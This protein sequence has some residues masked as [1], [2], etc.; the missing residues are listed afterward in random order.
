[1]SGRTSNLARRA[2]EPTLWFL[3]WLACPLAVLLTV[4]AVD[5]FHTPSELRRD[6]RR[7]QTAPMRQAGLWDVGL[8]PNDTSERLLGLEDDVAYRE[9]AGLY[10]KVE[11]GRVDYQG[12]P[13]LESMRAKAQYELTILSRTD[14][15]PVRQSRLLTLY[16]VM[17][18]D[19]RPL[20]DSERR[21]QLQKAAS[22]FRNAI[23]LDPTNNDAKTNLE[24][25]LATFGPVAIVGPDPEGGASQ[26]NTSGQGTTGSG[27]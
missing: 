26:G 11:P 3:G 12:F 19:A 16:G 22:A 13:E 18:L 1:V 8:L 10:L 27:Y 21:D 15:E 14:P 6:D 5:V 2:A 9:L 17:T 25:V 4:L 7:F 20:G 23:D 24:A